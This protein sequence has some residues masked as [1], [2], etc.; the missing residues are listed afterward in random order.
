MLE[1]NMLKLIITLYEKRC[2]VEKWKSNIVAQNNNMWVF[3]HKVY[4]DLNT[5]YVNLS[6]ELQV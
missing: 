2:L 5:S 3:L 6:L 1:R 4:F